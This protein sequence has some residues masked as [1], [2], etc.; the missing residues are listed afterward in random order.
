LPQV[1][2]LVLA[3]FTATSCHTALRTPPPT[4]A[5]PARHALGAPAPREF[6]VVDG[7][8]LAVH[9]SDPTREKPTVVCLHAIGHGG[10]DYRAFEHAFAAQFRFVVVDWPDQGWSGPDVQ[11]ASAARYAR[12][13][14]G[15]VEQLALHDV[16]L[17]GNSIGGAAALMYAARRPDVVRGLV[18]AN[19]GGLD[20]GGWLASVFIGALV[21]HFESGVRGEAS[22]ASWFAG[23]YDDILITSHASAQ[24]H[25]II[26]A[27]YESA[28]VLAQAWRSFATAEANLRPLLPSLTMPVLVAWADDDTLIQWQR[29]QD[30][31]LAIPQAQV[32]HFHAGHTA[33]LEDP[34]AFNAAFSTF[35]ATLQPRSA[36]ATTHDAAARADD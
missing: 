12:L 30:A 2:W 6:V 17:M 5:E 35:V 31:V 32:V 10:S 27:A 24:K 29:N 25:R 18:L 28:P 3:L 1:T 19:P 15:V 8:S 7:V 11:P 16:I 34:D 20:P 26:A 9:D 22:Y 33:F 4:D 14:A 36:Q 23:Y 13:L 21:A